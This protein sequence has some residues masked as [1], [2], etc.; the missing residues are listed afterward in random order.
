MNKQKRAPYWI[1]GGRSAREVAD[2]VGIHWTYLSMILRGKRRPS[3]DV[4]KLL[5]KELGFTLDQLEAALPQ[6]HRRSRR[7]RKSLAASA[8]M[9]LP[10]RAGRMLRAL[11]G[12]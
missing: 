3:L 5:A 11:G 2:K 7:G 9:P 8:P 4:A 12:V 6:R 1:L 10:I